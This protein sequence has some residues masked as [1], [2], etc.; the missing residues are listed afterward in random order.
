MKKKKQN[1]QSLRQYKKLQLMILRLAP[2]GVLSFQE[3]YYEIVAVVGIVV[4]RIKR[5]TRYALKL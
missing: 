1:K 3:I 4:S 5:T 2:N